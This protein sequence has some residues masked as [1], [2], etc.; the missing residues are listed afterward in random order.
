MPAPERIPGS[1]R[2]P[3]EAREAALATFARIIRERHPGVAVLPLRDIG[4]DGSVIPSPS[5]KVVRP[6][7]TPEDRDALL[8]RHAGVGALDD[9]RVD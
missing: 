7:A 1:S 9:D 5:R 2:M 6:F 8:H 3:R 4:T